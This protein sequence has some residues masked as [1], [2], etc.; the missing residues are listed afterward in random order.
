M[1]SRVHACGVVALLHDHWMRCGK[2]RPRERGRRSWLFGQALEGLL[3]LMT[4]PVLMSFDGD[5]LQHRGV[6][7]PMQAL[8]RCKRRRML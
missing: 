1:T 4:F 2:W 3:S 5:Q 7:C 6:V 8:C